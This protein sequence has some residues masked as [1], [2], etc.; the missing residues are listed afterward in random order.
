MA[1]LVVSPAEVS[2][3]EKVVM[4]GSTTVY[5][6]AKA[7]A[8]YYM[9]KHPDVNVT[10][11]GTGSGNGAKSLITG[12]CSI[13]CMSRF[14]KGKEFESAIS[15]GV[16]PVFHTVAMDGI[17]VVVNP[18]N[19]VNDLT[20]EQIRKI[21]N[22]QITNWSQVGGPNK[23]IVVVSRDSTSGTFEVFGDLVLQGDHLTGGA[24]RAA[25]NPEVQ[26]RVASTQA[27]IGYVGLGFLDGVKP[28]AVN[29]IKPTLKT[30]GSG[31]Y[32][33]ARPLFMVTDG[34]PEL[35]S[36]EHAIVT[37]YLQPYGQE[38]VK[39]IGFVPLTQY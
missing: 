24:E 6:V 21:Y 30:V 19:P 23:G 11:S 22:G 33:I 31:Q 29:G 3:A 37:M 1:G 13:A 38:M 8:G 20:V 7:F 15:N 18:G 12:R 36:P 25:S 14:M 27:A 32:P 26:N 4:D 16:Y 2:G 28:L 5:P 39:D 34:Y 10:V 17:A 35:G 9:A